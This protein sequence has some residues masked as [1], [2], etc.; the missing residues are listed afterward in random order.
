MRKVKAKTNWWVGVSPWIILGAALVLLPLFVFMTVENINHQK[1]STTK[2][3]L[4]KG[5]ALIR[6]FEAGART[7]MMG[8]RWGGFQVQRLLGET[9]QQ[10]DIIYLMVTDADGK[11][12]A[13][14][15]PSQIGKHHGTDL[16][17]GRIARSQ[18]VNRRQ[19]S[20]REH[21]K[22]FE[23]FRQFAPTRGHADIQYMRM[24]RGRVAVND[25]CRPHM[26]SAGTARDPNQVI[27][28][29]LDMGPVEA[30]RKEGMRNSVVM[31]V[32]FLLIGFAGMVSLFLAQAYRSAKTSLSRLKVFSDNLVE[33]MPMGL[34][35]IGMD[36]KIASFNQAAESILQLSSGEVLWKMPEQ[37]LPQ[38]LCELIEELKNSK[39]MIEKEIDCPVKGGKPIP[40]EVIATFLEEEYGGFLGYVVLFRDLT[41]ME[42]LKR[43]VQRSQRLASVGRLAAGVAHEIRNPLSSI[44]GFATYFK[45]RYREVPEDQ[46]TAEVMIQEVERLNRV[47]GQL[48]EFARPM[49][50]EEKPTSI[51]DLIQH[52]VKLIQGDVNKKRIHIDTAISPEIDKMM[53]DP[54]RFKQVLLN[55]Y[56]N[57]LEA[58]GAEGTLSVR[59]GRDEDDGDIQ[60][61][62]SDTG[63]GIR[64]ED[65]PHIFDPYFTSKSSGTGLGLAIVL[66]IIESHGGKIRVESQPGEGTTITI[67]LPSSREG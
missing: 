34:V 43:E 29:G 21:T 59:L 48:L 24:G 63:A 40:L 64:A 36:G 60:I 10:P 31:A 67:T 23:V 4:E 26:A 11:V 52:S 45:E 62:V 61:V 66:K 46:K 8:M 50:I 16:D 27:F 38:P 1:E 18:R 20:G 35:A 37:A 14:S 47:I 41:Q 12:L 3:L 28:V 54:D 9:A 30:A 32:A 5:A 58:M 49:R 2:L 22:I 39:G 57:A 56:L 53:I 55:L 44:K 19:V 17:L 51:Q 15:D 13:H 25:W 6:S 42:H 7:G 65:L 33:N